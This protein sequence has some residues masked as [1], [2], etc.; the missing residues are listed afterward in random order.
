MMDAQA[1]VEYED[2]IRD[3]AGMHAF[4][5]GRG[6]SGYEEFDEWIAKV[7]ES[8]SSESGDK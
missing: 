7:R 4:L 3:M 1:L 6:R 5:L 8:A 2:R